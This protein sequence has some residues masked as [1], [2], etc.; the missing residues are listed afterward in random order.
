MNIAMA[1]DRCLPAGI[2]AMHPR[3]HLHE[4]HTAD[5]GKSIYVGSPSR[6]LRAVSRSMKRC[7]VLSKGYPLQGIRR[8]CCTPLD[9]PAVIVYPQRELKPIGERGE[10]A[11]EI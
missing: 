10:G 1:A 3:Y 7:R 2:R 9:L 5:A 8:I 4:R 11:G 6:V